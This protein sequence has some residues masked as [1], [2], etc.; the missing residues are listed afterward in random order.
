VTDHPKPPA[1]D[2]STPNPARVWNYWSGGKDNYQADRAMAE[3]IMAALPV[4]PMTTRLT[5][6]FLL[7]SVRYL[8]VEHGIRQFLDIGSGLPAD[9]NSHQVAQRVDPASRVVYIDSDPVVISH[10]NALLAS[11]P[12]GRCDFVQGDPR[13]VDAILA[14][15]GRTLDFSRPVAVIMLMVLHF[16]LDDED[17]Y[18]L[19]RRLMSALPS[20]SFLVLVHATSDLDPE[21]AEQ[22]TKLSQTTA[23]P[24]RLRNAAEVARFFDGLELLGPGVSAGLG[25]LKQWSA[26]EGVDLI[27]AVPEDATIGHNG[28]ARKP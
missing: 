18:G 9:E 1:I 7:S 26:T 24:L 4:M 12:E 17:P 14:A 8:A 20:G 2:P 16:I 13:D 15:A 11:T 10:L 27:G 28:I 5:R 21:F 6:Q 22:V 3:Q 23:T 25:W 19:V